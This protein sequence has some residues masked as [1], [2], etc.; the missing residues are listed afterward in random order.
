MIYLD[1]SLPHTLPPSSPESAM[2]MLASHL[3]EL[4][5]EQRRKFTGEGGEE[6]LRTGCKD[7]DE[8][9]GGGVERG[10]MLGVSSNVKGC[11]GRLLSLNLVA[12]ALLPQLSS[13]KPTSK[14]II[15][16]TTGSFPLALLLSVLRSRI[17]AHHPQCSP[18]AVED[19]SH[20]AN[21]QE[22]T[23]ISVEEGAQR[24]LEMVAICRVFDV[25]GLWEV[26]GEV[27]Q[28]TSS[29]G[30]PEIV[31]ARPR[32]V[33]EDEPEILD[34]QEDLTS[35]VA[36]PLSPSLADPRSA[37]IEETDGGPEIIIIDNMT[38]LINE[39]FARKEKREEPLRG[40]RT[41]AHTFLTLLSSTLHTLTKT[42]NLLTLVHNTTTPSATKHSYSSRQPAQHPTPKSIFASTTTKPALGQVF[43]QFPDLHLFLH[44]MPRRREDA[45]ALYGR[46]EEAV[47]LDE[48]SVDYCTLI[49][50]LKDECPL[51]G[52]DREKERRFAWREQRWT[53]VTVDGD[54]TGL[55][56]AFA[57]RGD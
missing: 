25:E 35:E 36:I 56:A 23:G 16:D 5:E 54:G 39:L 53:A 41:P 55:V 7:I 32:G 10:V 38:H 28:D 48:D 34:S 9:L 49:E 40:L 17:L 13:P 44:G 30:N 37:Q 57:A 11:E 47:P 51:R 8:M 29:G 52:R 43:A 33:K 21:G 2:P 18:N 4:E 46:D 6:R 45:E 1:R 20:P 27:G 14:A 31:A 3:L 42:H 15:I 12:S 19:G 22:E 26:L 24:C 50:V